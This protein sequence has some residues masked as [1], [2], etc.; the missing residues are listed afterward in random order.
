MLRSGGQ[1][2]ALCVFSSQSLGHSSFPLTDLGRERSDEEVTTKSGYMAI[3]KV[4]K[5]SVSTAVSDLQQITHSFR[6]VRQ[7]PFLQ[8]NL[9]EQKT[10]RKVLND[11][12]KLAFPLVL[13]V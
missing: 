5:Y 6:E 13:V 8:T 9:N 7:R 2:N 11:W 10:R 4:A 3:V 1:S 12:L